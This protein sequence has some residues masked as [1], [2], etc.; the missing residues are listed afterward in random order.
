RLIDYQDRAYARLYLDRLAL[1]LERERSREGDAYDFRLTRE[2]ARHLA[3][4]MT[5]EDVIRVADLKSRPARFV[6]VRDE[7]GADADQPVTIV[8]Y[9][10]PG[11]EEWCAI[12]PAAIGRPLLRWAERRG[13]LDR[14]NIG[15]RVRSSRVG[16]FLMLFLL[17]R[18]RPWRR[19]TLRFKEE[20][21][22]IDG[23]LDATVKAIEIDYRLAFEVVELARARKGYGE[24]RRRGVGKYDRVMDEVVRPILDSGAAAASAVDAVARVREAALNDAEDGSFERAL[25]EL[26]TTAGSTDDAAPRPAPMEAAK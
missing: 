6:R 9:L 25:E 2:A 3:V 16:G 24:T 10:K 8:E 22:A 19:W 4:W 20:Q 26:G 15:L 5:F 7:A 18:L 1:L 17:A 23:W 13:K 12:L 11:L 21:Q 14:F